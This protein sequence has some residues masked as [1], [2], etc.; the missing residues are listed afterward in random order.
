MTAEIEKV[1]AGRAARSTA[2]P[3]A[4]SRKAAASKTAEKAAAAGARVPADH[5]SAKT[6]VQPAATVKIEWR[7]DPE[8]KTPFVYEIDPEN[9]DDLEFVDA[10]I[11]MESTSN[12]AEQSAHAFRALKAMLGP[13]EFDRFKQ[14]EV[15]TMGK[16]KFSAA[17]QFY[18]S[19]MEQMKKGNS[20]PSPAA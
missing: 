9:F 18:N 20:G 17:I 13:V 11:S 2:R 19:A 3:T 7:E 12:P 1:A 5:A 10:M 15:L 16:A 4:A 14:R 6:D 8:T